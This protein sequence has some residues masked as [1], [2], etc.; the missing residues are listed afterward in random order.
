M[1]KSNLSGIVEEDGLKYIPGHG[2]MCASEA[3]DGALPIGMNSPQVCP[4]GLY[5]EQLS[6]TAFTAPRVVNKRTWLYRILPSVSHKPFT[7]VEGSH[8]THDWESWKPNPNQMRWKPFDHPAD[9][10]TKDFVEGLY[11]VAGAGDPKVRHGCVIHIFSCNTGMSGRDRAFC[12]A[13]GHFLIVPQS[14][15]L[16]IITEMGKLVVKPNEICVIPRGI[17]F[18]VDVDGPARGYI[19]EVF[20]SDFRIPDLGPI[21]ANGLANPQDFLNPTAWY[22]DRECTFTVMHKYQGQLFA[23]EQGFSPFN[24]VAWRGNYTPYK[25]DLSR[26]NAMNS[27]TF[28]HADPSIFTVLTAPS[29]EPGTAVADFVIFPPRWGVANDTFR[30]P[31]FHRNAMSEFMGLILGE[32]E[33]KKDGF[34]PGG[35][36]LHSMM[37][38]HGPD[39]KTFE[40]A[41]RADLKPER[42]AEGT[43]A[44]MFES[45]LGLAL[46]KWG[47]ETCHKVDPKYYEVWQGMKKYFDPTKRDMKLP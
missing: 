25:Y 42:V 43:Q 11:T 37:T 4:Y 14:R 32:Y 29:L 35:G 44:F 18:A 21:G 10:E 31:Y 47:E 7:A 39:V 8:V 19:L 20:G 13:D 12:N 34:L 28:D 6:G 27:V 30:P 2:N 41:S 33:A 24:V 46:T 1:T 3:V 9:G 16:E 36:S 22:E 40:G 45:S 23:A 38:P 15:K 5:A 26:F 17:R